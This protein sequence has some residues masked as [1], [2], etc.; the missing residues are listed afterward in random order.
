MA[1]QAL[2]T[3]ELQL[4]FEPTTGGGANDH[5]YFIAGN[6]H[7]WFQGGSGRPL[8]SN[9][10]SVGNSFEVQDTA[11]T[12]QK[13]AVA[14]N[15]NLAIIAGVANYNWPAS[16]V[17]GSLQNDGAGNLSW[18]AGGSGITGTGTVGYLPRVFTVSGANV[19]TIRDSAI[20]D[21]GSNI[22]I[23]RSILG[24]GNGTYNIGDLPS[25]R[26]GAVYPIGLR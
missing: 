5:P 16:H 2:N 7:S 8:T 20:S 4:H 6:V 11:G 19:V 26:I 3:T 14:Q 9:A 23:A 10:G 1:D 12:V 22:T 18:G 15:G 13:F 21:D 25:K 17:A 24:A